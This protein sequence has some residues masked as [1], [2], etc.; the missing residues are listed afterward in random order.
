M[1]PRA[2]FLACLIF[3]LI[4][5]VVD[6]G[7]L[8]KA[9]WSIRDDYR[10][11]SMMGPA[12]RISFSKFVEQCNPPQ[13]WHL[14]SLVNR[15]T[16]YAVHS[17]WMFAL[18]NHVAAWQLAK[19]AVFF[20]G[21]LCFA[22]VMADFLGLVGGLSFT[23]FYALQPMWCDI[24]PRANCELFTAT[25]ISVF[26]LGYLRLKST[27]QGFSRLSTVFL[28][29]VTLLA[30][31]AVAGSKEN[32]TVLMALLGV[33][34]VCDLRHDTKSTQTRLLFVLIPVLVW[35]AIVGCYIYRGIRLAG[36]SNL[37]GS[38]LVTSLPG[39][40][41]IFG[42]F[43]APHEVTGFLLGLGLLASAL[44]LVRSLTTSPSG[45]PDV[46]HEARI[47][48]FNGFLLFSGFFLYYFYSGTI[49]VDRY[50]YP[51]R[52]LPL[53]SLT[54]FIGY[55]RSCLRPWHPRLL[56]WL[57]AG[58]VVLFVTL[59]VLNDPTKNRERAVNYAAQTR[60]F[61]AQLDTI[62][63]ALRTMP[64]RPVLFDSYAVYDQEAVASVEIYLR[65]RGITNPIYLKISGYSE[66]TA[67]TD[68]EKH[69]VRL[70]EGQIGPG[71]RFVDF[72]ELPANSAPL[73]VSFSRP[74][75]DPLAAA[76][77][78]MLY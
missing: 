16:Y 72:R 22:L 40:L 27:G 56:P 44:L 58:T 62:S 49:R 66:A 38:A 9:D 26:T 41:K 11:V 4:L 25:G 29:A 10:F 55:A 61:G 43:L 60:L 20:I 12:G 2:T 42:Q 57:G 21:L 70:I 68:F 69:M 7:P 13:D 24:V 59:T 19:V 54:A 28:V 50:A 3:T 14:G 77:V 64:G 51:Y 30:G 48:V 8:L 37:Y 34:L 23:L 31:V 74:Q 39:L 52:F 47:A 6:W 1:K 15:P 53:L 5:T 18:G 36:G 71:R 35:S 45:H 63:A 67:A 76:N 65:A 46:R 17:F 33:L 75:D 78:Q 73:V 32:F